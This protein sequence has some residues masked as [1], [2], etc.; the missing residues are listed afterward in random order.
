MSRE[1]VRTQIRKKLG[2]FAC[3]RDLQ[4]KLSCS[5]QCQV[6]CSSDPCQ[7]PCGSHDND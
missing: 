5:C 2:Q 1:V 3:W 7:A 4:Q 6:A